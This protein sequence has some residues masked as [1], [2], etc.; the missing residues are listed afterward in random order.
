ME[1]LK[2]KIIPSIWKKNIDE[3]LEK[4][5]FNANRYYAESN[6]NISL[7]MNMELSEQPDVFFK[8]LTDRWDWHNSYYELLLEPAYSDLVKD[9]HMELSPSEIDDI[10]KV[11]LTSCFVDEATLVMSGSIKKYLEYTCGHINIEDEN[12]DK[13][14]ANILLVT[15]PTETYFAQYQ[16]DHLYYIYLLKFDNIKSIDFKKH[17]IEKYHAGDIEIFENRFK[18]DF[19]NYL[20]SSVTEKELLSDI[21]RYSISNEYKIKHF[22]FRL[23]H[24]DRK[25]INDIIVYDNLNE[26]LIASNLIGISGF[27]LRKKILEYLNESGILNNRG[28]IYEFNKN[29][30]ALSLEKLKNERKRIMEKKVNIY[31]QRGDTCAIACMMMALEYFKL[32]SKANWYDEKRYYRIYRSKYMSGTP[33][34]ALAFHFSKN[35]IDTKIFHEDI[36]LF[37]NN[38]KAL[39]KEDFDFAMKEYTEMLDRAKLMGT[40]VINGIK[41]DSNLIKKELEC[42]N[43]VILAGEIIGGYHAVLISGYDDNH[44]V[45]CDP[46]YKTKQ[47]K[48]GVEL[49]KFMDTSIG[50]WFIS[51]NN[52]TKNKGKLMSNLDKFNTEAS[53]IMNF[54]EKKEKKYYEKK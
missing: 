21:K 12:L 17:L 54:D 39:K 19:K 14:E 46:L 20:N 45:V 11:Y 52:Y 36:N 4:Q 50:K 9:S 47:L 7:L 25:A 35:G 27:L 13:K 49:N 43:L 22:Y 15:P 41:I 16:I 3:I 32:I 10:I 5:L 1:N 24:P 42:G 34:S 26:K 30:V 44:F 8:K 40:K 51:I 28:Y 29:I 37:N 38:R 53:A 31:K 2:S 6:S 23:E 33:F 48:T 18:R